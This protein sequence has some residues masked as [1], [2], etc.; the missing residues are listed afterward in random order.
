[1]RADRARPEAMSMAILMAA[2][3]AGTIVE[4]SQA[5]TSM[6]RVPTTVNVFPDSPLTW[7]SWHSALTTPSTTTGLAMVGFLP[8]D[9]SGGSEDEDEDDDDD[10]V[11]YYTFINYI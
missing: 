11:G 4:Q 3:W 9:N 2:I 7:A 8:R 5:F 10:E 1:M 6:R